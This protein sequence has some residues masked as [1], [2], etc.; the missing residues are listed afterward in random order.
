MTHSFLGA[1]VKGTFEDSSSDPYAVS[2]FYGAGAGN[3]SGDPLLSGFLPTATS[4]V[5]TG[6]DAPADGFFV[7]TSYRGAFA[8]PRDNWTAGWTV[9]LPN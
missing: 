9:N 4:P 5:L 2:A 6:G 3:G 8:G 1:C 7:P